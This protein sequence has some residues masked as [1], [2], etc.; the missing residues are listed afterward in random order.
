MA[1]GIF[2]G[3]FD[4]IHIGHLRVAEEVREHFSLDK[5]L[6]IPVN[7]PPHKRGKPI[8]PAEQRLAM[9]RKV[10]KGSGSLRVSAMEVGR[11][12]LSYSIDTVKALHRLHKDLYF[13]I[14]MDAFAELATWRQYGEL[15]SYTNFIVMLRASH[16]ESFGKGI[17][18]PDV[19]PLVKALGPGLLEHAS[20]KKIH[21]FKVTTLDVSSTKIR[22]LVRHGQ[23]FRYLVHPAVE[24]F[25][26]AEG[27]YRG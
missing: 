2:G 19:R 1:T 14:G 7:M 25:I 21:F 16:Q 18:P 27:L 15:F 22:E 6:F 8:T 26:N 17:L 13:I 11:G 23:S 5:V 3:T 12:G 10:L 9:L 24:R 4:P 20:G